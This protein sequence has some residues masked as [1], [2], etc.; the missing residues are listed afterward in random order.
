M[1]TMERR[2]LHIFKK[3]K[4]R[5]GRILHRLAAAPA[6]LLILAAGLA[7]VTAGY[8]AYA[9]EAATAPRY[10][11]SSG[12]VLCST[13]ADIAAPRYETS[14]GT[15]L[16][17]MSTD[18]AATWDAAPRD[19]ALTTAASDPRLEWTRRIPEDVTEGE[20]LTKSL[21]LDKV[22]RQSVL[23]TIRMNWTEGLKYGE[24]RYETNHMDDAACVNFGKRQYIG[25]ENSN[26]GYN[27]TGFAASVLYYA[28]GRSREDALSG[29][30]D[31]Y[32]PFRNSG[33]SG[34][35]RS[36]T[37]GTGWYYYFCEDHEAS[38]GSGKKVRTLI[39]YAG[40]AYDAEEL[41]KVLTEAERTGRLKEGDLLYFW[42]SSGWD[43]HLAFYAG[44]DRNRVHQMYHAAGKGNHNGVRLTEPVALSQACSEG[45]SYVYIVPLPDENDD[46][47]RRI[48]GW[49]EINGAKYHFY[50]NGTRTDG[51]FTEKGNWYYF[52]PKTGQMTTGEAVIGDFRYFFREDGTCLRNGMAGAVAYDKNGIGMGP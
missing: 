37:D 19:A 46:P 6:G 39:N 47:S 27:C 2:G 15:V 18:I 32:Q 50:E 16:C 45:A 26:Y 8:R 28:D 22:T 38:D 44:R 25:I 31:I 7:G 51:W 24:S 14:S 42:P 20:Y 34:H 48:T 23:R 35:G 10:E 11:A 1:V 13:S 43:C 9:A 33:S 49:R 21:G 30:R 41:Q 29:M 12:T 17:S 40:E 52:D 5:T 4:K 36:F 3:R